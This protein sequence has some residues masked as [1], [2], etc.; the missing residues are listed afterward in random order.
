MLA[1][2][3]LL[4]PLFGNMAMAANLFVTTYSGTLSMLNFNG[5]GL[6]LTKT[7]PSGNKA[8]SWL[9]Y[10]RGCRTLYVSDEVNA[11]QPAGNLLSYYI[12]EDGSLQ[13]TG[14]S[15]SPLGTVFTELYGGANGHSFI[16]QAN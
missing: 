5:S 6:S 13:V 10:D 8:P 12:G 3:S 14:N 4:L 9:T 15:S 7:G 1:K 2:H 11:D 16:A